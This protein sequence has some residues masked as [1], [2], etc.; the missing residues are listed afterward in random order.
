[1]TPSEIIELV[2]QHPAQAVTSAVAEGLYPHVVLQAEQ[3]KVI[4]EFLK[5]DPRLRFDL[6][7]SICATDRLAASQVELAYDLISTVFAHAVALKVVLD[8]TTPRVESVSAVWPTA[9]WH[10]R[11]AYDLMGV[12][13]LNHPDLRRILLP[14][15]WTGHPLRKD[16]QEPMEYKGL[17][18]R[19]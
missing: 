2:K 12:T 14:E 6:L 11:E 1:M 4:A 10:E 13:F 7:R 17:K 16:D 8:R 15:D 19:P 5:N 3:L 9:E 18:L